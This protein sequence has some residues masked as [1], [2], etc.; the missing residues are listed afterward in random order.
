MK[1]SIFTLLL[2]SLLSSES[3]SA[4]RTVPQIIAKE[5]AT[6]MDIGL[7]KLN[8]MLSNNVFFGLKS[9]TIGAIY[10]KSRGTIDIKVSNP[11]KRATKSE[12][13]KAIKATK[14]I[15][16]QNIGTKKIVNLH[17]YFKHEGTSYKNRIKWKQLPK[18]VVV[19]AIVLTKKNYRHSVFCQSKLL[20]KRIIFK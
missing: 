13:R 9:A 14:S 2:C 19:T 8:S 20:S 6:M 12:C 4:K 11:V 3:W 16:I 1:A 7:L 17:P 15:F 5:P 18:H 10:N